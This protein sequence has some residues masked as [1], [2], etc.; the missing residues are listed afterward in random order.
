MI[1]YLFIFFLILVKSYYQDINEFKIK[2]H[3]KK[4]NPKKNI[5]IHRIVAVN[6]KKKP[7]DH[8]VMLYFKKYNYPNDRI[9]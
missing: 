2:N 9:I 4:K 1:S 3:E 6:L 8:V 7:P 5:S